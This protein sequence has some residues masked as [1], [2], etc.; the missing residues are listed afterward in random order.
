MSTPDRVAIQQ[1]ADLI[2]E[3]FADWRDR[4]GAL[5]RTARRRFE[6][7]DWH[8]MQRDSARR[9]DLYGE[10]VGEGIATLEPVLKDRLEDRAL[11]EEIRGAFARR[12][13]DRHDAHLAETFFNSITRRLFGTIGVDPRVEF[14]GPS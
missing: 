13:R 8:A 2:H 6:R 7:R 1:A 12:I 9:L 14:V 3:A 11:W 4:F 10:E 5:T